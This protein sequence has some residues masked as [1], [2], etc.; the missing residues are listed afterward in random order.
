MLTYYHYL[1]SG[2]F[3]ASCAAIAFVSPT[4]T[5]L[6]HSTLSTSTEAESAETIDISYRGSGRI[7]DV[8]KEESG[9]KKK[10]VAHRGSGRVD[11][12]SL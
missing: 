2:L 4:A 8:P 9:A 1:L 11:P 3:A 7:D 12:A 10:L 5:P 6:P